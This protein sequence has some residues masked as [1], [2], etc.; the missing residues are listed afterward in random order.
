MSEPK[1]VSSELAGWALTPAVSPSQLP[2]L[3]PGAPRLPRNL[4]I[5]VCS[6]HA[7]SSLWN[8]PTNKKV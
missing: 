7:D 3:H 8:F 6:I 5:L 2:R 1:A 4:L